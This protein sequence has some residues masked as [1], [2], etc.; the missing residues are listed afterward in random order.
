MIGSGAAGAAAPARAP[1]SPL[2]GVTE[3]GVFWRL[4]D[5]RAADD[6]DAAGAHV[7]SELGGRL[8]ELRRRRVVG[9]R[10]IRDLATTHLG[11]EWTGLA[12]DAPGRKPRLLGASGA[13][14]SISHS[15]GTMLVGVAAE[16]L[17]GV[18][19]EEEPFA[20]FDRPSLLRRMCASEEL[21]AF[22][23]LPDAMRRRSLA[24][25]WTAKEATLKAFGVGLAQDPRGVGIDLDELLAGPRTRGPEY[26]IVHVVDRRILLRHPSRPD[27][28][29][30]S[31][32]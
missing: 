15:D 17:V 23:G 21:A 31:P 2:E 20:A 28:P 18:D 11:L 22:D 4:G 9:R 29:A 25:A 32:Q 19:V 24:R 30:T 14:A 5:W 8:D 10:W 1:A 12:T 3:S 7:P 6:L 13:D 16:G 26:S 27:D